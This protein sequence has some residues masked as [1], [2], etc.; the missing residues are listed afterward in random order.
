MAAGSFN[1]NEDDVLIEVI[2]PVPDNL[3]TVDFQIYASNNQPAANTLVMISSFT[4][5]TDENGQLKV[6]G[7]SDGIYSLS[8]YLSGYNTHFEDLTIDGQ[9]ESKIIYLDGVTSIDGIQPAFDLL[10][11]PNPA[12]DR[13]IIE[14]EEVLLLITVFDI[15]GRNVYSISPNLKSMELDLSAFKTGYY[16]IK[17]T[18]S[19]GAAMQK[20]HIVR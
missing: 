7:L 10:L 4:G 12:R 16:I 20:L 15:I 8:A 2:L 17:A 11:Y 13:V 18:S 1:I 3:Y 5:L 9:E 19:G 6:D 14:S